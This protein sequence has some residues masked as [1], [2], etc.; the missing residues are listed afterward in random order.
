LEPPEE[1]R[2][3]THYLAVNNYPGVVAIAV[4]SN[5][6][7]GPL[8][9]LQKILQKILDYQSLHFVPPGF[10]GGGLGPALAANPRA[11]QKN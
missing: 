11:G 1:Q 2:F 7:E 10:F 4:I 5:L 8:L 6:S 9:N 3:N